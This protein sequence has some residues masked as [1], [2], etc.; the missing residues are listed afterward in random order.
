[1]HGRDAV[2]NGHWNHRRRNGFASIPKVKT[3]SLGCLERHTYANPS[4]RKYGLD[5][6]GKVAQADLIANIV[7]TL[8]AGCFVGSLFSSWVADKMGRRP[9]L[10]MNGLITLVGCIFQA[11]ANGVL[12]LMYIG[13]YK[14]PIPC[15]YSLLIALSIQIHCRYRCRRSFHSGSALHFRKRSSC[16]SGRIDRNLS[17]VC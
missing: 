6:L 4:G 7:S 2:W 3:I 10:I 17:I 1:M 9:S 15:R 13:R 12:P 16:N 8:Q 14:E 11:A 5:K